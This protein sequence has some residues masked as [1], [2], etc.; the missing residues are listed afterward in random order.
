MVKNLNKIIELITSEAGWLRVPHE[1]G[2]VF[3]DF[4]KSGV[5]QHDVESSTALISK[6]FVENEALERGETVNK[7]ENRQ[8]GHYWLRT[9]SLSPDSQ[10]KN[11]IVSTNQAIYKFTEQILSGGIL[12]S[13]NAP[14]TDLILI[15]IGGSAL[16]PQLFIDAF[17]DKISNKFLKFHLV[18]NTDPDGFDQV[19]KQVNLATTLV[20]V[21]SKSGGTRETLN[22]QT[23]IIREFLKA[24]LKP[25][26]HL[27]AIT[28]KNSKLWNT[29]IE[30]KWLAVF[31]VWDW[32]GG[33]TS[34]FSA[35]GLVPCL[36]AGVDM[37]QAVA[38]ASNM[39]QHTRNSSYQNNPAA[40]LALTWLINGKGTGENVFVVLP[41]RDKLIFLSRYLQ[42]LIM[43][44]IGKRLSNAGAVVEQGIF[45]LGNKGSTDQHALVQQLR[46]GKSNFLACFVDVLN[47]IECQEPERFK[48]DS[49]T[50]MGDYL[51]GFFLGTRKAFAENNRSSVSI[52]IENLTPYSLGQLVAFFERA[53]GFYASFIEVNAYNQPG[54]EAGKKAA[55]GA[56]S[57]LN[58]ILSE[59]SHSNNFDELKSFL[60]SFQ[61]SSDKEIALRLIH[62]LYIQN[63]ITINELT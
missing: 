48:V 53:V 31:E 59:L 27:V 42:Q 15:G 57:L 11:A 35:V 19:I 56:V 13:L 58:K 8:V 37:K 17:G 28:T 5:E 52:T 2:D 25:S 29:A 12:S 54:V 20:L 26:S 44:S 16:G 22:G 50:T 41:Y 23:V 18:D 7:D 38:G 60:N 10:T 39:D 49:Q 24:G 40:N 51:Q 46:D 45:V 6:A 1:S 4:T 14:F 30:E 9:P 43:E 47:D 34:V 62:R 36:L 33:R 3:F 63:R 21:V 61:D 32:V 55:E